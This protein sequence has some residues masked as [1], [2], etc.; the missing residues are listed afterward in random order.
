MGA[1]AA[2]TKGP[3]NIDKVL[4]T[5]LSIY[6]KTLSDNVFTA[7]PV[8]K[9]LLKMNKK[10]YQSGASIIMPLTYKKNDTA[11]WYARYGTLLT[12]PQDNQTSAQYKWKQLA[13]AVTLAGIDLRVN[14]GKEQLINL[15]QAEITNCESSLMDKLGTAL[16]AATQ[17]ALAMTTLVT[18]IDATST[19]GDINSSTYDWWQAT[20][21]ASGSF[22]GQGLPDMRTMYNTLSKY[23]RYDTP[24][25]I[26]TTQTI[27]EYY[28]NKLDVIHR[29]TDM[30]NADLGFP[31]DALQ[32]KGAKIIW[33]E[34]A[35]SGVMYFLN[36]KHLE[37]VVHSDADFT[38]MPFVQAI[39]QDAK[40]SQIL[41]QL[42]L[43]TDERR[44]LGKLTGISA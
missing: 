42:E 36:S 4:A 23:N 12:T 44:K 2:E 32:F 6:K 19:I 22:A 31:A 21:T 9:R 18:L 35:T 11:A 34:N 3:A 1:Y 38:N 13:G 43:C 10:K 17:D 7:L 28:E 26:A 15:L 39:N 5:T 8:I 41:C 29:I 37:V 25:M 14:K 24:D 40:T 27:N 16:Y 33:D 20:V 30:K